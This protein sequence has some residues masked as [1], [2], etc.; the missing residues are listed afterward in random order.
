MYG[1]LWLGPLPRTRKLG[2]TC[3]QNLGQDNG[4]GPH[5]WRAVST[6]LFAKMWAEGLAAQSNCTLSKIQRELPGLACVDDTDLVVNDASNQVEQVSSKM[7][8]SLSMWHSQLQ[9]TEGVSTREMLLVLTNFKWTNQQWHYNKA[10]NM[11][12]Q[13]STNQHKTGKILVMSQLE[14]D[15]VRHTSCARWQWHCRGLAPGH[16]SGRWSGTMTWPEPTLKR[17]CK[18]QSTTSVGT[19]SN[20]P[21]NCHQPQEKSMLW[22]TKTSTRQSATSY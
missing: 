3:S 17:R 9:G 1:F 21:T 10:N 14:P 8:Q 5:I 11:L 2:S 16:S 19:K 4:A 13:L 22:D 20:L 7:Q 12:G 6:P 18:V 15:D